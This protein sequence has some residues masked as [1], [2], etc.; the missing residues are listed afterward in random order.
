MYNLVYHLILK[1]EKLNKRI[2]KSSLPTQLHCWFFVEVDQTSLSVPIFG[3]RFS[4]L[5]RD[6]R[7]LP[8]QRLIQKRDMTETSITAQQ[9]APLHHVSHR[10][11]EVQSQVTDRRNQ[12]GKK[13]AEIFRYENVTEKYSIHSNFFFFTDR[14]TEDLLFLFYIDKRSRF[15]FCIGKRP[16]VLSLQETSYSC[17]VSVRNLR[18][19]ILVLSR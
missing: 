16:L 18:P 8:C 4:M 19:I 3:S 10:A 14:S 15:R 11:S 9:R 2:H 13:L 1:Q 5:Y 7:Q 12:W 6:E 17:S